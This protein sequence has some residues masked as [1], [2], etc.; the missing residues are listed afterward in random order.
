MGLPFAL[1]PIRRPFVPLFK[2]ID[3]TQG[4]VSGQP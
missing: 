1:G 4:E 2:L 3:K